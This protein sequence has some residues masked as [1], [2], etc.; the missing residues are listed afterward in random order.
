[1]ELGVED[2]EQPY[3]GVVM[4]AFVLDGVS[5]E[6]AIDYFDRERL[7]EE[8]AQRCPLVFKMQYATDGYGREH[9][10]PGGYVP[11][12]SRIYRYLSGLRH[13][14]EH[15]EPRF[16]V[17]GRFSL[18]Y[19]S[20][21]RRAA[22]TSLREQMQFPYEGSLA[23][24]AYPSYLRE[25]ALSRVCIDLPGN[26]DM[27]HRLVE[28]LA[29]G[30]CVVR[31]TPTT[32]L[33]VPLSDGVHIRYAHD[34]E[35]GLV[36]CCADLLANPAQAAGMGRAARDYF[37]RYLHIEQLAG[38]YIDRCVSMLGDGAGAAAAVQPTGSGG[39]A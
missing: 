3:E 2:I 15:L 5:H 20:A 25:A 30:A 21:T 38:Y 22:I 24:V 31:P 27:C 4:F 18:S 39:L 13:A 33:H 26:G 32:R 9:V 28:Y 6:V 1:M 35:S 7:L 36:A 8:V 12:S 17:Y 34:L 16:D 37:D 11:V 14:R 19:A 29:I 23:T 10:I